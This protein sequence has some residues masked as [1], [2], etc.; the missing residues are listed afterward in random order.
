[1]LSYVILIGALIGFV[2][3]GRSY[4]E[5]P[6]GKRRNM[7]AQSVGRGI[8]NGAIIFVVLA[9]GLL[10]YYLVFEPGLSNT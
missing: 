1:M 6:D 5:G 3:L 4:R 10:I 7:L 8:K 2:M 9:V